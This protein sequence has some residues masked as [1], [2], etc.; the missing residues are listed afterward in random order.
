ME[1]AATLDEIDFAPEA[2]GD[3]I[4][5]PAR[6]RAA[7]R[8]GKPAGPTAQERRSEYGRRRAW[9]TI[10][11]VEASPRFPAEL[12]GAF[13]FPTLD[14]ETA[15]SRGR[16]A[17]HGNPI[18]APVGDPGIDRLIEEIDRFRDLISDRP[19][20]SAPPPDFVG[21]FPAPDV[22]APGMPRPGSP[23]ERPF[24]DGLLARARADLAAVAEML[25]AADAALLG[26]GGM[27]PDRFLRLAAA[28]SDLA[29]LLDAIPD[30]YGFGALRAFAD[31]ALAGEI[32]RAIEAAG[33]PLGGPLA[34][35]SALAT[36]PDRPAVVHFPPCRRD[37]RPE[38]ADGILGEDGA[39]IPG[40]PIAPY[41]TDGAALES[42]AQ[43]AREISEIAGDFWYHHCRALPGADN[44]G[45]D[46]ADGAHAAARGDTPA[47]QVPQALGHFA[48][49]MAA[50]HRAAAEFG[51]AAARDALV[52][53]GRLDHPIWLLERE[54]P[55]GLND[56]GVYV[57]PPT[58]RLRRLA[59]PARVAG[60]PAPV[61]EI[62][63]MVT[64]DGLHHARVLFR[65]P[66]KKGGPD[67]I[68]SDHF[69]AGR[70]EIED[71]GHRSAG[72]ALA[73]AAALAVLDSRH[74][75][76]PSGS[77]GLRPAALAAVR[78]A[79]AAEVAA[80][81]GDYAAAEATALAS[82]EEAMEE[83]A[84]RAGDPG[85]DGPDDPGDA[86]A[87]L[88][89]GRSLGLSDQRIEGMYLA[90]DPETWADAPG[91]GRRPAARVLSDLVGDL[92]DRLDRDI[93]PE[94][95]IAIPDYRKAKYGGHPGQIGVW[96]TPDGRWLAW[97][98]G[99]RPGMWFHAAD[100]LKATRAEALEVPLRWV[101]DGAWRD[102]GPSPEENGRLES[103]AR[104]ARDT[105]EGRG[106]GGP[107]PPRETQGS[108][109][110]EMGPG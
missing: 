51:P 37:G 84:A 56:C 100:P 42:F 2:D 10:A 97:F 107:P 20:R 90:A 82:R 13:P 103:I 11:R 36:G 55:H 95:V 66:P 105:R 29:G 110:P 32:G 77:P 6:P 91:G 4:P 81:G 67:P 89:L 53:A 109:F 35:G 87:V 93:A 50:I 69:C 18:L 63:Q 9:E 1:N 80:A 31:A 52:P 54:R 108:L 106:P 75:R 47:M 86:A 70:R 34:P 94:E 71:G 99:D 17:V 38:W 72:P 58:L 12:R 74:A 16:N 98:P 41:L 83:R 3:Q 22:P 48:A 45:G 43:M 65:P 96:R 59:L 78:D 61:V 101:E 88:S 5:A 39:P 27:P 24:W 44:L 46:P 33:V 76:A 21:S 8:P 64:G 19:S 68:R 40:N 73:A 30:A 92:L 14:W 104:W 15:R 60:G 7:R 62:A 25:P 49:L 85:P 57:N 102:M 79:L 23:G 26:R 28:E